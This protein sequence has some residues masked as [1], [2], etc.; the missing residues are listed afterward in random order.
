MWDGMQGMEW[1]RDEVILFF[2][3]LGDLVPD[4]CQLRNGN[5][6]LHLSAKNPPWLLAGRIELLLPVAA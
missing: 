4:L 5:G 3:G 6:M 1:R 2:L